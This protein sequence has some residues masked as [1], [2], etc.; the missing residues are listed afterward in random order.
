MELFIY[1]ITTF[2]KNKNRVGFFKV[3]LKK[4]FFLIKSNKNK[5]LKT[6]TN[7]PRND[8]YSIFFL[9]LRG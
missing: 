2:L 7:K 6:K 9:T 3:G 5:P 1:K 4:R 8:V